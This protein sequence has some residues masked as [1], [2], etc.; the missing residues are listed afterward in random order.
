MAGHQTGRYTWRHDG[1][2]AE[3]EVTRTWLRGRRT[4]T[5]DGLQDSAAFPPAG[6]PGDLGKRG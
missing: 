5:D 3:W 1:F 6:E 4:R 2:G